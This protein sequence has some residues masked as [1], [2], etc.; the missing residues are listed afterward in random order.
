MED[1]FNNERGFDMFRKDYEKW[2]QKQIAQEN[3]HRR[4]ELLQKGLSHGSVEM[5]RK[6]WYPVV[7]IFD[8]LYPEW[9]VRD[10]NN[11]GYRYLD[12]AFL[13]GDIKSSASPK[14]IIG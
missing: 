9:E 12:F 10:F 7:G 2:M 14:L 1:P 8:H 13:P 4:R 6:I 3:N 11:D 5:L